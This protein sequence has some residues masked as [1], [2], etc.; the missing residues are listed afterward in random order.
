MDCLSPQDGKTLLGTFQKFHLKRFPLADLFKIPRDLEEQQETYSLG[1][2]PSKILVACLVHARHY[3]TS[4]GCSDDRRQFGFCCQ[5]AY[6]LMGEA[7]TYRRVT[8]TSA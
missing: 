1:D 4:W 3:T 7:R 8:L 6:S 2:S 5:G